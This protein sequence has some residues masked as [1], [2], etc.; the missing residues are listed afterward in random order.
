ME[1]L[2]V[3]DISTETIAGEVRLRKV[4]Q[5]CQG[6]GQR[7]QKSVF[8][9]V[10]N[11]AQFELLRNDLLAAIDPRVDSIRIYRLREPHDRYTFLAG[12]QIGFDIRGPLVL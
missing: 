12:R 5:V 11:P 3:Y 7:V 10:L 8:E 6:Y 1:L 9:C 2:V 4:A